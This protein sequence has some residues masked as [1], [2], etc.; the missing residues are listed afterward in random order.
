MQLLDLLVAPLWLIGQLSHLRRD[1][2]LVKTASAK[3][4]ADTGVWWILSTDHVGKES[5]NVNDVEGNTGSASQGDGSIAIARPPG[6]VSAGAA[7][8]APGNTAVK[9]A[10]LE[11]SLNT[12]A[13]RVSVGP[14]EWH[15]HVLRVFLTALHDVV[16]LVPLL[17]LLFVT[18][19]RWSAVWSELRKAVY[20]SFSQQES[21]NQATLS[22]TTA[23]RSKAQP[24]AL[25]A[26]AWKQ[27]GH[28]LCDLP[29]LPLALIVIGTGWRCRA[30][31]V[32]CS[33]KTRDEDQTVPGE[34]LLVGTT[35][36]Q[37]AAKKP[38][39]QIVLEQFCS[40]LMD[41]CVLPLFILEL[42]TFVRACSVLH[43]LASKWSV[44]L[45]GKGPSHSPLV[46]ILDV[47]V[48]F[49]K[50]GH[51]VFKIKGILQN[52]ANSTQS[53]QAEAT[54]VAPAAALQGALA[55]QAP[56][57]L[58][59]L[60]TQF[61]DE[62]D[63]AFD[64]SLVKGYLPLTV[65]GTAASQAHASAG[66]GAV[67][68]KSSFDRQNNTKGKLA[69]ECNLSQVLEQAN[70]RQ[71]DGNSRDNIVEIT[72]TLPFVDRRRL[73]NHLCLVKHSVVALVQVSKLIIM[74]TCTR[75]FQSF[76]SICSMKA[77]HGRML[78]FH[79]ILHIVCFFPSSY[80]GHVSFALRER[81]IIAF[82]KCSLNVFILRCFRDAC[83][84]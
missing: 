8:A 81:G 10:P 83:H 34:H 67:A 19:Y 71:G 33:A 54:P 16:L 49:P 37:P 82:E 3:Q 23:A 57:K 65:A 35:R 42:V 50:K 9:L 64:A 30:L 32:A 17:L 5:N 26:M 77:H 47:T 45:D 14:L 62:V 28:L 24:H 7:A 22:A 66:V 43:Q 56:F 51:P 55:A 80:H 84:K 46:Q 11:R 25:R 44:P 68:A 38:R 12:V 48:A 74:P 63:L 39:R 61:W 1:R 70:Q 2:Q 20:P 76:A 13:Q 29:A 27:F 60:G 52:H 31:C 21:R 6:A 59:V 53:Q 58:H 40:L 41:L 75:P 79:T 69:A 73:A 4:D 15:G 36:S 72:L 78:I 18:F